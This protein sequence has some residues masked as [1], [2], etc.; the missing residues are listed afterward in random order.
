MFNVNSKEL[1][2]GNICDLLGKYFKALNKYEKQYAKEI[3]SKYDD[4]RDIDQK[5]NTDFFNKKLNML[6]IHKELSKL[7]TK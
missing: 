3:D 6:P 5:E 2:T 7:E 4:Y 1:D